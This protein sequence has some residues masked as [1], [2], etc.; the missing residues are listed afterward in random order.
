[1][2]RLDRMMLLA[3]AAAFGGALN[4][5]PA[6]PL[7]EPKPPAAPQKPGNETVPPSQADNADKAIP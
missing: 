3:A 2:A 5:Q 6:P 1:M 4:A 7:V